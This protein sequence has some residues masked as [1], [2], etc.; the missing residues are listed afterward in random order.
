M[1]FKSTQQSKCY[2]LQISFQTAFIKV[3]ITYE[4]LIIDYNSVLMLPCWAWLWNSLPIECLP[5]T[6]D[7]NGFKP[8]IDR[9][10]WTV[11]SF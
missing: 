5:F 9:H 2:Y 4:N 1:K 3:K 8:R 7:L 10:L 6:Y 11:G